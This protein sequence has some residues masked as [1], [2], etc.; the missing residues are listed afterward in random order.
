MYTLASSLPPLITKSTTATTGLNSLLS[1]TNASPAKSAASLNS[2][3]NNF[4]NAL[5]TKPTVSNSA[6]N[7]STTK[8]LIDEPKSS[9][10][11]LGLLN[12]SNKFLPKFAA[13]SVILPTTI[14]NVSIAI[15][16]FLLP[17]S[18]VVK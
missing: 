2:P 13:A 5:P 6:L 8:V 14:P 11:F 4:E 15:A 9:I 1:F 18:E 16:S 12:I 7:L 10:A 3:S 17:S